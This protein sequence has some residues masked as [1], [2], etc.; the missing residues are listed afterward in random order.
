MLHPFAGAIY[1]LPLRSF[2]L[3]I[4]WKKLSAW[5]RTPRD[6]PLT[7]SDGEGHGARTEVFWGGGLTGRESS[8]QI[9]TFLKVVRFA[10]TTSDFYGSIFFLGGGGNDKIN[11]DPIWRAHIFFSDGTSHPVD[12]FKRF[13]EIALC[14]PTGV[15]NFHSFGTCSVF[16]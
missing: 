11:N 3:E 4:C 6:W 1:F 13:L 7:V 12:M 10:T 9:G 8:T 16:N 14:I 15:E 2:L 5:P